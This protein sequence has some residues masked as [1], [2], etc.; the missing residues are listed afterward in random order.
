MSITVNLIKRSE[1]S[2]PLSA[3]EYDANLSAIQAAFAS[4]PS[5]GG[6]SVT[7]VGLSTT[8]TTILTIA[9]TP[10]VSSGVITINF[11]SQVANTVFSG[12]SSGANAAP[13]FRSL[14][15]NDLPTVPISKLGTTTASRVVVTSG[16]GVIEAS[17]TIDTTELSYLDGV[18][19]NIQ[20]QLN[21]KQATIGVLGIANGGTSGSTAQ[22][23]R[24]ALLPS[25][26]GNAG[27]YLRVNSTPNDVE[28][29]TVAGAVP[30]VNSLTGAL[31]IT[32]GSSG[33]DVAVASAGS[34]IT[35]NI[36]SASAT[37]RGVITTSAQTIAGI[38]TFTSAPIVPITDTYI[39][40]SNSGEVSG[41]AA[42]VVDA[43]KEQMQVK[44]SIITERQVALGFNDTYHTTNQTVAPERDYILYFDTSG[45]SLDCTMFDTTNPSAEI[46]SL[47]KIVKTT[48]A[49]NLVIKVQG[50]D[51]IGTL[52]TTTYTL[53]GVKG[54][55][56]VQFV[57]SGLFSILS[58]G[59]IS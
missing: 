13:T 43:A 3:S 52:A 51:S 48:A 4:I 47:Y 6:G 35:V 22:T 5:T 46:G 21:A 30:S 36:P 32:S 41:S 11:A 58:T 23:A 12:P 9:S 59:T 50:S 49:N 54:W 25:I 31:T 56:E 19:S 33:T 34:T 40:Y 29:V 57:K 55:V 8:Q 17:S 37:A 24:L 44:R 2:S 42:F 26:T 27:K 15:A 10:V 39:M 45:G 53:T 20:T 38:K 1:Q 18:T 16:A 7:S 14:V 28:W